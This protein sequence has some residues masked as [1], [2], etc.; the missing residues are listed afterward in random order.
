MKLNHNYLRCTRHVISSFW[1]ALV[2]GC[3][4]FC[5]TPLVVL[6]L[7]QGDDMHDFMRLHFRRLCTF[8]FNFFFYFGWSVFCMWRW[9][10]CIPFILYLH[11]VLLLLFW[12]FTD[13]VSVTLRREMQFTVCWNSGNA[14]LRLNW[15]FSTLYGFGFSL[16]AGQMI[17]MSSCGLISG[18]CLLL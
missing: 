15:V 16:D 14:F 1:T 6:P 3:F 17:L 2:Y 10:K 8:L 7:A 13:S 11:R 4:Y 12:N 9:A 5:F 18:G